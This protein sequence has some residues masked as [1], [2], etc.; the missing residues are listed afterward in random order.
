VEWI[1]ASSG[2]AVSVDA[3][4]GNADR[5]FPAPFDGDAVM[6]LSRS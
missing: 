3:V 5:S 4:T 2:N 1:E 6:Y